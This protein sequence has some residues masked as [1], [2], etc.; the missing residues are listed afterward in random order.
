VGC[1]LV[2]QVQASIVIDAASL[3]AKVDISLA[4]SDPH[5]VAAGDLDGD[6]KPD[7]VISR[8]GSS[9]ITIFR[10]VGSPGA[11][12]G[13]SFAAGVDYAVSSPPSIVRLADLDGDGLLDVIVQQPNTT[14]LIGVFRNTSTAGSISLATRIDFA[15]PSPRAFAVKDLDGDGKLDLAVAS[16]NGSISLWRNTST[17]GEI[18]SGSFAS[19]ISI[20][21]PSSIWV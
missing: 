6:G 7:L 16:G 20:S 5:R 9:A 18:T 14:E 12:S 17:Q 11:I 2:V 21:A 8:Y 4:G 3:A 10:N 13:G 15:T 1:G 19:A